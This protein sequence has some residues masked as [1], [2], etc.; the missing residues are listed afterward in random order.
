MK[1]IVLRPELIGYHNSCL[2]E[3]ARPFNKTAVLGAVL[4]PLVALGGWVAGRFTAAPMVA[5]PVAAALSRPSVPPATVTAPIATGPSLAVIS[6]GTVD[7]QAAV[8]EGLLQAEF[9]GNGREQLTANVSNPGA[10]DLVVKASFGQMFEGGRNTVVVVRSVETGIPAGKC[11]TFALQTVA[12]RSA[13]RIGPGNYRLS[14]RT[15]PKIDLLLTYAQDHPELSPGALQTA[16]LALIENLPLSA[17]CKFTPVGADFPSR[18]DTSAFRAET[19]DILTALSALREIGVKDRDLALSIDPQLK[20]ESMIEPR[21]RPVAMQHYGLNAGSEWE[22]WKHELLQ[23]EVG[24]RHYALFGIARFYPEVA[25]QMLPNWARE[26]RTT[27]TFRV[28]AVQ[29]LAETQRP[30]ALPVLRTLANELGRNTELGRAALDAAQYLDGELNKAA[31][32]ASSVAFR[33]SAVTGPF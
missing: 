21:C 20:I 10:T 12:T 32:G 22:Y 9:T 17:L 7:L 8:D 14:P 16:V 11:A 33:S 31:T 29:A 4:L 27:Q 15:T 25:V 13:N 19:L 26:K 1:T 6:P 23:G 24:T 28:A 2:R 30:D 3:P 18:F 5:P